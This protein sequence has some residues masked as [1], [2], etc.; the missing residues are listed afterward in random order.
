[1]PKKTDPG[2]MRIGNKTIALDE[3]S[4]TEQEHCQQY[5][6]ITHPNRANQFHHFSHRTP[7]TPSTHHGCGHFT[8]HTYITI[9]LEDMHATL[10]YSE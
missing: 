3:E 2:Y 8:N 9:Q 1:M 6:T 10:H 5:P 4:T 7:E